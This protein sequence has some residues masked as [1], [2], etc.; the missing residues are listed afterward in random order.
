VP[1]PQVVERDLA[2]PAP[3]RLRY[4][5][6]TGTARAVG[7][8]SASL[9]RAA[10]LDRTLVLKDFRRIAVVV[11]IALALLVVSGLILNVAER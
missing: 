8:P 4:G 9:E 10:A 1:R 5:A 6:R 2:R 7:A 3:S 11:A